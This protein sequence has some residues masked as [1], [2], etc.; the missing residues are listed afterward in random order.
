MTV[1]QKE[2]WRVGRWRDMGALGLFEREKREGER[3]RTKHKSVK[4]K[5]QVRAPSYFTIRGF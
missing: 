3:H 4:P 5:T 2:R 1:K